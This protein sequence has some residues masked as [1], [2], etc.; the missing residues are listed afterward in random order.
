MFKSKKKDWVRFVSLIPGIETVHPPTLATDVKLDWLRDASI[1]Y[2]ARK[3]AN[4]DEPRARISS[5]SRCPGISTIFKYAY[6]MYN[7]IDF[8][9]NTYNDPEGRFSSDASTNYS[10]IDGKEFIGSHSAEQLAKF[11]PFRTDTIHNLVKVQTKWRVNMSPDVL[12][13]QIPVP[14]PDHNNFTAVHGIIDGSYET[15]INVQLYWHKKNERVL[16]KAGTPLCYYVPV[17][18]DWMPELRVERCTPD[19]EYLDQAWH[20][21]HDKQFNKNMK[22]WFVQTKALVKDRLNR[23]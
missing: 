21:L 15:T 18:R 5:V 23:L 1:D 9:I 22:E 14:Y 16:I 4:A 3:K 2:K 7:P 11:M 10:N 17:K 8:V 13:L 19:D 12:L 6:V 20:Y